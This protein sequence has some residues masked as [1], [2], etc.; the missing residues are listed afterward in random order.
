MVIHLS[1]PDHWW[2]LALFSGD[3]GVLGR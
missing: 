2:W 1:L 3:S